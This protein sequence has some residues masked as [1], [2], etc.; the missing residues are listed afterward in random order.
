MGDLAGPARVHVELFHVVDDHV[1]GR[2]LAQ[3]APIAEAGGVGGQG[4]QPE[5]GLLERDLALVAHEPLQ[6]V[7]G[8]GAHR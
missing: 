1:G 7:G 6:H 4:R 5:V 3:H 8:P 2:A